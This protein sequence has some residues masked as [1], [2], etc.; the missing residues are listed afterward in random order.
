VTRA[1]PFLAAL[2][3]ASLGCSGALA[4]GEAPSQ[5]FRGYRNSTR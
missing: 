1:S 2:A 3:L 4:D 5:D